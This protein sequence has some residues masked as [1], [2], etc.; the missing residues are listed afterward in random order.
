MK[1]IKNVWNLVISDMAEALFELRR[2]TK[3][4]YSF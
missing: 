3:D 2:S 1:S 4:V